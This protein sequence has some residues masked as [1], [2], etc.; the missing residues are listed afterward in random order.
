MKGLTF[1]I[2]RDAS[3]SDCTNG[4]ISARVTRGTLIG[5]GIP[6]IFDPTPDA[7]AFRMVTRKIG[8]ELYYHLEPVDA[9]ANKWVMFGGNYGKCSDSRFPSRYPLPIHDRIE[10]YR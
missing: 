1:S 6:E 3:G 9:P 4:G 5:P 2:Y 8:G 10:D 7:P